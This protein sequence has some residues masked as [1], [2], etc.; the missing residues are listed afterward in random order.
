MYLQLPVPMNLNL[1]I[2]P[3]SKSTGLNNFSVLN[4]F[5]LYQAPTMWKKKSTL[6]RFKEEVGSL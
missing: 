4:S 2:L 6:H 5:N 1:L 3:E